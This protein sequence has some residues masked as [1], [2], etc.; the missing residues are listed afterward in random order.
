MKKK[1]ID[2]KSPCLRCTYDPEV[3]GEP[4]PVAIQARWMWGFHGDIA[5]LRLTAL[6]IEQL[7][8]F[9]ELVMFSRHNDRMLE[10]RGSFKMEAKAYVQDAG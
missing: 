6:Q 8:E 2:I 1:R 4:R 7:Y 10:A 5:Y 9:L 3:L